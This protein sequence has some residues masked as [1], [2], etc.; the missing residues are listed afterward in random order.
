MGGFYTKRSHSPVEVDFPVFQKRKSKCPT[1]LRFGSTEMKCPRLRTWMR[2]S[3]SK[4]KHDQPLRNT[5]NL[6]FPTK[7]SFFLSLGSL[8]P[9]QISGNPSQI[10]ESSG[11]ISGN[12]S[13]LLGNP[14]QIKGNSS[15]ISGNHGQILGNPGQISSD[16]GQVSSNHGQHTSRLE[17]AIAYQI[18]SFFSDPGKPGVRSLGPDVSE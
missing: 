18:R 9:R 2:S 14:G 6:V 13:Y 11:Q 8:R 10:S 3:G 16:L 5:V 1:L 17:G 4:Q 15:Q 7:S 12:P